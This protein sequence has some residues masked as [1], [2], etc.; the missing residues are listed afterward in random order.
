MFPVNNLVYVKMKYEIEINKN[1]KYLKA[2]AKTKYV[3]A[4]KEENCRNFSSCHWVQ[5]LR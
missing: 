4:L 3:D 2:I 1:N 5:L